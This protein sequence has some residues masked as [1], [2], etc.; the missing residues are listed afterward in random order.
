MFS[1]GTFFFA[2]F[3]INPRRNECPAKSPATPPAKA[4]R[5]STRATSPVSSRCSVSRPRRSSVRNM[6]PA[7]PTSSIH[8]SSAATAHNSLPA[9]RGTYNSR[10]FF[11][12]SFFADPIH[13]YSPASENLKSATS[14]V[15]S[16]LRRKAPAYPSNKSARSRSAGKSPGIAI[17]IAASRSMVSASFFFSAVPRDRLYLRTSFLTSG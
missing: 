8:R 11:R 6:A 14:S 5:R 10:P 17:K 7:A 13:T 9:N 15:S 3:V 16:S 12:G 2:A 1:I 4:R